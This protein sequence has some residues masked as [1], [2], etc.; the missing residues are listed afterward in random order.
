MGF[1]D[2]TTAVLDAEQGDLATLDDDALNAVS[3][4]LR[5][6]GYTAKQIAVA[7]AVPI[8]QV[9]RVLRN[10]R[11]SGKLRDVVQDLQASALPLAVEQ[12]IEKLEAGEPWAIKE[13][14]RGLGA[15]QTHSAQQVESKH[16]STEL[17]VTF[18][19]APGAP[20]AINP[21]GIVGRARGL[22]VIDAPVQAL[23]LEEATEVGAHADRPEEVGER[24]RGGEGPVHELRPSAGTCAFVDGRLT[25]PAAPEASVTD[26]GTA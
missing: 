18:V 17:S 16:T 5:V 14:L 4:A 24:G 19:N 9:R 6:K 13:T 22:E 15:F 25:L 26:A 8:E 10:G 12:L 1:A 3:I 2:Q 11:L 7:M 23:R 20:M 21:N